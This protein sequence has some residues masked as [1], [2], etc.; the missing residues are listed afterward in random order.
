MGSEKKKII[1][2]FL[3][4][5]YNKTLFEEFQTTNSEETK[6]KIDV[7]FKKY[8][9]NYRILSYLIKVLHYES[10]HFD[11]KLRTYKHRY[12][13]ILTNDLETPIFFEKSYSDSIDSSK[14]IEDHISN[15]KLFTC[16]KTLTTRQ[17]EILSLVYVRQMTDKEIAQY[18]G[19]TQQAVS[20]T[21]KNVIKK[22]RKGITHD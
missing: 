22:I 7:K 21:R 20:K 2:E 18:L 17:K 6:Q 5:P 16:F 15:E 19:I 14:D 9:Q 4:C 1:Q 3:K 13:L 12:Q 8:Y 10:K 11:H